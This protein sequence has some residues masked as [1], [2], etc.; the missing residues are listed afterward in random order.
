MNAIFCHKIIY[1]EVTHLINQ[2]Y[3]EGDI[4]SFSDIIILKEH[5]ESIRDTY[6]NIII[7]P[8]GKTAEFEELAKTHE[9]FIPGD[10]N[11]IE[12]LIGKEEYRK[13]LAE[14]YYFLLPGELFERAE[15]KKTHAEKS[16]A[17]GTIPVDGI[18][19]ILYLDT[20][21]NP[22]DKALLQNI[23]HCIGTKI[24][25]CKMNLSYLAL[26]INRALIK[27]NSAY[28]VRLSRLNANYALLSE[29][30]KRLA[31]CT[32][33]DE[34][35]GRILET[36]LL[37]TACQKA[38]IALIDDTGDY[39]FFS[40]LK[41]GS[42]DTEPVDPKDI[43]QKVKN[44]KKP[45]QSP[46]D[47]YML[48]PLI[49]RN[50]TIGLVE[51]NTIP[52]R[53]RIIEYEET[54]MPLTGM[55][56]AVFENAYLHKNMVHRTAELLT[57]NKALQKEISERKR[58]EKVLRES[59][60]QYRLLFEGN[61]H[62]MW[63]FDQETLAFLAVND[64]AT[65]HYGYS[66][67]EFLSLTIK[68]ICPPKDIPN[69]LN[70]LA[71]IKISSGFEQ[72]GVWKHRK[73]D[74][75]LI[76]VEITMNPIYFKGRK[77]VLILAHDITKRKRIEG[78]LRKLSNAV[79]QSPSSVVIT[80]TEGNIEYVNPKFSKVTGYTRKE[81]VSQNPRILKSGEIP[82]EGYKELWDT[83]TSGEEW[84]GEFHNKK[85]NGELYWEYAS[86]SP[87]KNTEGVITHFLAV[88]EDITD[89]KLM[90]KA[91][92]ESEQKYRGLYE[93]I[94]DGI[95]R[96][97]MEGN[98]LD[99]NQAYL[100][101][102]GYT[103]EEV[104]KLTYQQITPAQWYE[105]EEMIIK[106]Q[107]VAKGYSDE[108]EKEYIKK[109]GTVFPI[110]IKV[111]LIKNEQGQPDGMWG[112]IR[113]ISERKKAEKELKKQRNYLE[114]L[115]I[116]LT[117]A[118]QELEAFCYSVSHDLRSPLRNMDGFSKALLEDYPDKLDTQG[119]NYLQ[120]ISAASQRMG[121]LIDDLLNLSRITRSEM[122]HKVVDLSAQV[123]IIV[124]ELQEK[125]PDRH[126]E[127]VITQGLVVNGDPQ[128]LKIALNNLLSNAWKFTRN[129]SQAKI[130]FGTTRHNGNS[131]FFVRDNGIGF[132]MTYANKLFGA[133]QRLHSVTEFEG[134]GIG[135]AT[136]Q[137]IIH[138][139]GGTVRAEGAVN[140]GATIYFTLP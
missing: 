127:F 68:D 75:T 38:T 89:R 116:Q 22:V 19:G 65:R 140:Q 39:E 21:V 31:T 14:G 5:I 53:E 52:F 50:K 91:L 77:A 117:A 16:S 73:K 133:F 97:D 44:G 34:I 111:W 1:A 93:S 71:N 105:T 27:A 23:S 6:Q 32:R 57:T 95:V 113:D 37:F 92:Q 108:Y 8:H 87:I 135:L 26:L 106:N 99:Y 15:L 35:A 54:L 85:K 124:R 48:F 59:E 132:D 103:K 60:S 84:R 79:E 61:P 36:I 17:I 56:A 137:R 42:I 29:M 66:Q 100:D 122:S 51:I 41:D 98:I 9:C 136:V 64:I 114:N 3:I 96:T 30:H 67:E 58:V 18:K 110:N 94:K 120:R 76:D 40:I 86:I 102:L 62:P 43:W 80:D 134:T 90:E 130:E 63:V 24:E 69:L 125:H 72:A 115:T 13:K 55:I 101:M 49:S 4:Y 88:K 25:I 138:R 46:S 28:C 139:H 11:C 131:V 81:A 123:E 107:I 78:E 10:G 74:G 20:G 104:T 119:K 112:I 83:I 7:I 121:Q 82:P 109:D 129:C 70:C 47:A 126:V 45:F 33:V 2:G 12:I 118:N 128:L